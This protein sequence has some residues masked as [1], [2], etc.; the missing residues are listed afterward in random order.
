MDKVKELLKL[1][2]PKVLSSAK[3]LVAFVVGAVIAYLAKHGVEVPAE[4][5]E[6]LQA[7]VYG[8]VVAVWVWFIP[9][10]G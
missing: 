7:G 3:A 10:K 4:S 2:S 1:V 8:I 9:N 5:A 6:A